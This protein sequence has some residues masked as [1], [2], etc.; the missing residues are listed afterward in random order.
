[1][2]DRI[3]LSRFRNHGDSCIEGAG[4]FNLMIGYK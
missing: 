1:M 2:L 3:L 4:K